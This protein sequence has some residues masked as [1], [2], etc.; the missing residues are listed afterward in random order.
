MDQEHHQQPSWICL[1]ECTTPH[2]GG[3]RHHHRH[4][5][6]HLHYRHHYPLQLT[7]FGWARPRESSSSFSEAAKAETA[8]ST[9]RFILVCPDAASGAE[10]QQPLA[11]LCSI[12]EA[13]FIEEA[14]AAGLALW[15]RGM[16][17]RVAGQKVVMLQGA[18]LWRL[19]GAD[20]PLPHRI[21][22]LLLDSSHRTAVAEALSSCIFSDGAG[23]TAAGASPTQLHPHT[24]TSVNAYSAVSERL[25]PA[26]SPSS[27]SSPPPPPPPPLPRGSSSSRNDA[28][29]APPRASRGV[30]R[31]ILQ[32]SDKEAHIRTESTPAVLRSQFWHLGGS[33][34]RYTR[35]GR[36]AAQQ[37]RE[38]ER[39]ERPRGYLIVGRKADEVLCVAAV[40]AGCDRCLPWQSSSTTLP[41]LGSEEEEGGSTST[42]TT[43][44]RDDGTLVVVPRHALFAARKAFQS[45]CP[46][47]VVCHQAEELLARTTAPPPPRIITNDLLGRMLHRAS[48][49]AALAKKRFG[50]VI[51]VD[52]PTSY[53]TKKGVPIVGM[54]RAK[55]NVGIML[56]D[57]LWRFSSNRL[58]DSHIGR[59]LQLGDLRRFS[60]PTVRA[61]LTRSIV[62]IESTEKDDE[63]EEARR[64]RTRVEYE[65]LQAP[66][67]VASTTTTSPR[68][69]RTTEAAK[70]KR[71]RLRRAFYGSITSANTK[72]RS[73]E[74]NGDIEPLF[75][76][77]LHGYRATEYARNAFAQPAAECP[78]CFRRAPDCIAACGHSLCQPC[79]EALLA[80]DNGDGGDGGD[81]TATAATA[82][83]SIVRRPL[84]CPSCKSTPL[85]RRS[86]VRIESLTKT[87]DASSAAEPAE[88]EKLMQFLGEVLTD[89]RK[90]VVLGGFGEMHHKVASR[91]RDL[92][93]PIL[94][95]GGNAKASLKALEEFESK[96]AKLTLMVDNTQMDA[97]WGWLTEI[98]RLVILHPLD[99]SRRASCCQVHEILG[100]MEKEAVFDIKVIA[101]S[102]GRQPQE[103][104]QEILSRDDDDDE[105]CCTYE[106][107]GLPPSCPHLRRWR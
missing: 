87:F 53:A 60:T 86:T 94:V 27:P 47:T 96:G 23:G 37:E 13:A 6:H 17:L 91:L 25:P 28:P 22:R 12:E 39:R 10:V 97:R 38:E 100:C 62:S 72:P 66:P 67:L 80:S 56:K 106:Q 58:F 45:T 41:L 21:A 44:A 89:G 68:N 102:D 79:L 9:T 24:C 61:V 98:E 82:S 34:I 49:R 5:R 105:S 84:L 95:W 4:H 101:R 75:S 2:F 26:S 32:A 90:K 64:R 42:S 54:L 69:P 16:S 50:R 81:A 14:L 74:K 8:A 52:S 29:P 88:E 99:T 40:I 63:D 77:S 18:S 85:T 73:V 55:V 1:G 3:E 35:G 20:G 107:G 71:R 103:L 104:Q 51:Y 31:A 92:G 15:A 46:D 43:I 36:P 33:R 57:E 7:A 65:L 78:V 48:L 19:G 59:L 30:L 11:L 70:T 93:V 76:R 83:S